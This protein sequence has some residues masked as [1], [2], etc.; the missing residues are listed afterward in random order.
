MTSIAGPDGTI[1]VRATAGTEA[2]RW[3]DRAD[4]DITTVRG[5]L[6]KL[7]VS[8][9]RVALRWVELERYFEALAPAAVGSVAVT[10]VVEAMEV[11]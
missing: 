10:N 8:A 11:A 3:L 7:D 6:A 2:A 4:G 1:T 9:S 5:N